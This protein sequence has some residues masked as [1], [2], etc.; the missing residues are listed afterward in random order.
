MHFRLR[1]KRMPVFCLCT[2]SELQQNL[3]LSSAQC[4]A[5]AGRTWDTVPWGE[6]WSLKFPSLWGGT[7]SYMMSDEATAAIGKHLWSRSLVCPV[8]QSS[9]S[10]TARCLCP[11]TV[12]SVFSFPQLSPNG[13]Q[14]DTRMKNVPVPVYCR[15]LV[16]KDPTMKVCCMTFQYRKGHG[17]SRIYL[18][19]M[20]F[21]W[22]SAFFSF[23]MLSSASFLEIVVSS[24]CGEKYLSYII[25]SWFSVP[26][27]TSVLLFGVF[28]F[29]ASLP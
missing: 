16:E 1:W 20:Q 28:F 15:P 17:I 8:G 24:I 29:E 19:T 26:G 10:A 27:P 25:I 14:E 11:G 22:Q 2:G 5:L 7:F 3:C 12:F 9:D 4:T 6:R 21:L 13:G 18:Q 23:Q